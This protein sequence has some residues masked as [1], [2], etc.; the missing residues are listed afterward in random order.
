MLVNIPKVLAQHAAKVNGS[1]GMTHSDNPGEDQYV[2]VIDNE[3][4]FATQQFDAMA[5]HID[6]I[7]VASRFNKL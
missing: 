6:M 4:V 1:I 5:A 2:L 7:I 3:V